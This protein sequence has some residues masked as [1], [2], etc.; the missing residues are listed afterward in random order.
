M[1]DCMVEFI[2]EHYPVP[3]PVNYR[4]VSNF[5]WIEM[6]DCIRMHG[7]VQ[8]KFKWTEAE[9]ERAAA[10]RA[11]GLTYKDIARNLSPTLSGRSVDT[12]LSRHLSKPALEPISAD[13]LREISRLVD[14]YAGKYPV[15]EINDKIRTQLNL[16]KR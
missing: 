6:E 1:V 5:M 4:A 2:K 15:S 12:A 3:A 8:G 7:L 11:Q 13:E 10:L 14:E 16:G 9:R